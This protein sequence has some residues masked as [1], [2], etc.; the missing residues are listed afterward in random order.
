MKQVYIFEEQLFVKSTPEELIKRKLQIKRT[1]EMECTYRIYITP[2]LS[3]L[4][5]KIAKITKEESDKKNKRRTILI[6]PIKNKKH[7]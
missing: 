1:R 2:D 4:R 3:K 7:I 5:E 6:E